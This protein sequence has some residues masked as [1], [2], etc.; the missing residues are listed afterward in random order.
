M[1][2][3]NSKD[4]VVSALADMVQNLFKAFKDRNKTLPKNLVIFRD[5]ISESQYTTVLEKELPV[6][7]LLLNISSLAHTT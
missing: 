6:Y 3:Q 1:C 5:G 7:C 4:D 2:A